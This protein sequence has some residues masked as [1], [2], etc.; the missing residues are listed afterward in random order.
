[1]SEA[2]TARTPV[3][4]SKIAGWGVDAD[5][6]ND[7]TYPYRDRSRDHGLSTDWQRPTQQRSDVEVLQSIEYKHFPAVYGTTVPPRGVSGAIRRAAFRW[8]E[9]HWLHWLMLMGADRVNVVEGLVEDLARG[10]VPNVPAEMGARAEWEHNRQGFL[11]KAAVFAGVSAGV[12][13]LFRRSK[14]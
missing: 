10:K 12:V 8:S 11:T 4:T 9:S 14:G 13:L 1:M 2:R 3:D 6:E 5:P 7:P